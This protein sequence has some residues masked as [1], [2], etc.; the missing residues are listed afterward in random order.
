MVQIMRKVGLGYQALIAVL[1]GMAVGIFFGPM[2]SVL[3]P[4]GTAF[5][6]LLQMVVLPYIPTLLMHGIG[7]LSPETARKL[8]KRG[9][10]FLVMLWLIVFGA[11]YTLRV[12]IPIPLPDPNAD[13]T[14]EKISF[15]RNFL[16]Y[17]IPEN[18]FYDLAHNVVPAVAFFS[19]ILGIALMHLKEKEPLLGVLERTNQSLEKIIKWIASIS[20]IGIFAHIA[21]A[22]GTVNLNDLSKLELFVIMTILATIFLSIWVL[23]MIVSCLTSIPYRELMQEY[24]IVCILAF[25]TGIPSIAFPFINNC[26]RRLAER[27][28]LEL[29]TFRSTSQ[30]VVPLAYSFA[31]IGNFFLLLFIFFMSFYF[32]H[33]LTELQQLMLPLM[34]IPISFGTPQLSLAGMSF[35][36][37]N[38]E[39][40]HE[41]FTLFVEMTA[42]TLNFQVLLSVAAML[43]FIMLVIL[44]YYGLLQINWMRLS[45]QSSF[46]IVVL[47]A[48]VLIGKRFV[49][50]QDNYH[51]LYYKMRMA[52]VMTHMPKI[53][54]YKERVPL[55]LDP[56]PETLSRILKTSTLRVAYDTY[57][58]PFS[59]LNEWNEVVGYDIA[60]A[61]ELAKDLDVKLE[62][63]PVNYDTMAQ[64][65]NSGYFDIAMAAILMTDNRVLEMDFARPYIEQP[66]ALVV[67]VGKIDEFKDLTKV[68]NNPKLKIGGMGG[69][70][71]VVLKHFMPGTLVQKHVTALITGELDATMWSE[72]PAYIWCMAHPGYTT[73]SYNNQL[74]LK[75]F[76]YPVKTG[77]SDMITFLN[78]WMNLKEVSGF[79]KRQENYWIHGRTTNIKEPRWSIIRNVLHWVD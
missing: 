60:Y 76:A 71:E 33:P 11:I 34:T 35:L 6:M 62:L 64:D 68:E 13:F 49:H 37:D 78:E 10:I 56:S 22:T 77:S 66:N 72:L 55:P 17:I 42:I 8:F 31:Q 29:A 47:F 79:K 27:N 39:F 57:A 70:R 30:T 20:P 3:E 74:G 51:D 58:I 40:P 36:T 38:L 46:M 24:R 43:T 23:P 54:V 28:H 67:P 19:L 53:K 4:I 63:I 44:R 12:L 7:S 1:L 16:S 18:P 5:I 14:L 50:I 73:L 75:Y 48:A 15:T 9:F 61:Y 25:A 41:A 52:D 69:Y 32:R 21:D 45:M 65:L 59:Y 26:M 2:C